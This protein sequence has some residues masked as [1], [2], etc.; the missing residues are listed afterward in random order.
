VS[1]EER[2]EVGVAGEPQ[3]AR[4]LH[5]AREV[6]RP[7]PRGEIEQRA[8]RSG[9]RDPAVGRQLERAHVVDP[10]ARARACVPAGDAHVDRP[11]DRRADS[12]ERPGRIVAE[13]R[14]LTDRLDRGHLLRECSGHRADEEHPVIPADQPTVRDAVRDAVVRQPRF[15]ERPSGQDALRPRRAR[16]D[17]A[18]DR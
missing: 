9:D 13:P 10:D 17:P 16:H 11:C 7:D 3:H 4:L 1:G 15:E 14:V 8:R 2:A 18:I 5:R 6:V 12:P